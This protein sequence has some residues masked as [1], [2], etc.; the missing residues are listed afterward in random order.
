MKGDLPTNSSDSYSLSLKMNF[1]AVNSEMALSLT[2][3]WQYLLGK[4]GKKT[5]MQGFLEAGII[6]LVKESRDE[7]KYGQNSECLLEN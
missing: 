7:T 2:F 5:V 1:A 6:V 4:L 3:L